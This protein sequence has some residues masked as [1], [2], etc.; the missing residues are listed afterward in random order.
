[1]KNKILA[2]LMLTISISLLTAC[3]GGGGSSSGG[4]GRGPAIQ[5]QTAEGSYRAILRPMNNSLSGFLPTGA[6]EISIQGD[7]VQ[8]KTYLDDDARVTHMQN[9]HVGSRCPTHADDRNGD[10]VVDIEEAY[11][12]VG[13]VLIPLDADINSAVEGEKA[14]PLGGAFTY[15][16][17]ASLSKLESDVQ[18]RTNQNLNLGGRV[19]LIHGV[20]GGTKMP[21]TVAS[22]EG[23]L[24]QASVPVVCGTI[25]R[26]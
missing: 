23:M 16:E 11:A 4:P 18:A 24:M 8:A 10:G 12:V 21:A 15:M 6:A 1:M 5:E 13:A 3:G 7:R 14:Y 22:R 25:Q 26:R 9:V 2:P 20:N 19:V 17:T